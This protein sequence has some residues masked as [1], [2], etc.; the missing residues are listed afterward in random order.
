MAADACLAWNETDAK[1]QTAPYKN[2]GSGKTSRYIEV[3]V[4]I[5]LLQ[6]VRSL[7]ASAC[8]SRDLSFQFCG[9]L[10]SVCHNHE[11]QTLSITFLDMIDSQLEVMRQSS[12][13][14]NLM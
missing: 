10:V 14:P 5:N 3:I 2:F 4:Y 12:S 13:G 1:S 7:A 9:P 11:A 8:P 6:L